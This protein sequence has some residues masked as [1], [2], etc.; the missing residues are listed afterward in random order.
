MICKYSCISES[1]DVLIDDIFSNL[2]EEQKIAVET[3]EGYVRVVAGAGSGKTKTLAHRYA[4]IVNELGVSTSNI[5]CVTFTNKAANEMKSRIRRLIG[6]KDLALICTF[7]G[8]CVQVLREDIYRINYPKNFIILDEEDTESILKNIYR[9]HKIKSS[10]IKFKKAREIVS[11]YKR[12][13]SYCSILT[14]TNDSSLYDKYINSTELEDQIIYGYLYE[15]KKN[16]GLDFDDLIQLTLF[17]FNEYPDILKKWQNKLEYVMVDEFQDVSLNQYTL[18]EMISKY[19]EN[20]FIV[21]DP[22]QTI[23]SWRGADVKFLLNFDK[24]HNGT[25]TIIM[26]KN[27][28]SVP[29]IIDISNSLISHNTER[30]EKNLIPV[31]DKQNKTLYYHAK[32]T[33]DESNWVSEQILKLIDIG[34]RYNDIAILYRAHYVS[35]SIE[36]SLMRNKIPYVIF[37]GV[38]FYSRKE[39]K[40]VLCYLRMLIYADDISFLRTINEPKRKIGEKRI[41]FLE[42]YARMY[43]CSLYE[44]LKDNLTDSLFSNTGAREYVNLIEKHTDSYH[45][46]N[47]SDTLK[48]ILDESKYEQSLREQGEDERLENLAELVQSVFEFEK[49][50]TEET[51]LEDYLSQISLYTNSDSDSKKNSIKMMTIH[52]AKGLEYPYVFITDLN[53]GIFPSIKTNTKDKL[54]EERRLAYV[55]FTRAKD[56]LFICDSEGYNYDSS[57]R[58][59][60]RFIFNIKKELVEYVVELDDGITREAKEYIKNREKY[61]NGVNIECNVEKTNSPNS[62]NVGDKITHK[63][64]GNGT[65]ME[66][67]SSDSSA[68]VKFDKLKTSRSI[69]LNTLNY[70]SAR[71]N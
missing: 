70:V 21:G 2:N 17:I 28:R 57:F 39:I 19:H 67:N 14:K 1:G 71:S 4:Y 36:E 34:A 20:L 23:Y 41:E 24:I 32:T 45:I 52:T 40:D 3:T 61:I 29:N 38:G 49:N 46:K 47:I 58:Y 13:S 55:A 64:F 18:C 66:I 42:N 56:K 22:D 54:E 12:H 48:E 59:P 6:D 10:Q 27:Y 63:I 50:T 30:I 15:E 44:A 62:I 5:L 8:F 35:R 7:H 51:T 11:N 26:N 43:N 69:E 53:E 9:T 33:F 31:R 37:S 60:S 25:R 65:I 68:I 16:Y